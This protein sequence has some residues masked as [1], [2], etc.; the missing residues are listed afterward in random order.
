MSTLPRRLLRAG[1]IAA[2]LAVALIVAEAALRLLDGYVVFATAL[3]P[4]RAEPVRPETTKGADRRYVAQVPRA[5]GVDLAWYDDDPPPYVRYPMEP[6]QRERF[7][8]YVNDPY[9]AFFEWNRAYLTDRVCQGAPTEP[10][11][12]FLFFDPLEPGIFPSYRHYRHMSPPGWFVSNSFGWRGPE[13]ALNKPAATIRIA[14]VGASTTISP[15]YL[16]F[17]HPEFVGYW[18]NRWSAATHRPYRFEVV[19]AGRTGIDS[20]SI[21]AIVRQELAP[22]EPDLVVFYE[23]ANQFWPAREVRYRF[24]RLYP[25]PTKTYMMRP[26]ENRFALVKRVV[27]VMDR[28]TG[29]DGSEPPKPSMT[30][31]WTDVIDEH[32]PNPDDPRLPMDLPAMIRDLDSM[33]AAL[34]PA[35]G[36]LVVSSFLWM[37]RDG[38]KLDLRLNMNIY[39]YLNRTYWPIPYAHMRR[40]ADL[41][42]RVFANYARS[43]GLPFIDIAREFPLDP[44]LFGDAIHM[45][46]WGL[47]LQAWIYLQQLIP[48][49]D[50]RVAAGRLP[51]SMHHPRATHPAFEQPAPRFVTLDELRA[52]CTATH[53]Q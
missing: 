27:G 10:L 11:K 50:S 1:V 34:Q 15:Y 26:G 8:T 24:G 35:D 39:D 46:P 53:T 25:K 36:E 38:M 16:P 21:A 41:Q 28:I 49:I 23:G 44:D 30:P 32:N 19:N 6:W 18:L 47:R 31:T 52:A 22:V 29:R 48:L 9:P 45:R 43:R 14:F 33:K 3:R 7:D 4:R 42:N 2:A 51:Q 20:N 5:P 12:S 37:V 40:M 13:I 17:S